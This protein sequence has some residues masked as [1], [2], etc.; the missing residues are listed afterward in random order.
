MTVFTES[1]HK[2][3]PSTI[4]NICGKEEKEKKL[5]IFLKVFFCWPVSLRMVALVG[6]HG[7]EVLWGC[8]VGKNGGE[9]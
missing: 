3:I 6:K 9:V 5:M 4:R 8:I 7:G 1:A 2:P